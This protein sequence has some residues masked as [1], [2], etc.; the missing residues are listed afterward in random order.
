MC[1]Y[2]VHLKDCVINERC[3]SITL[4]KSQQ[5]YKNKKGG[6]G[7]PPVPFGWSPFTYMRAQTAHYPLSLMYREYL[8][9]FVDK[10]MLSA[11]LMLFS[12]PLNLMGKLFYKKKKVVLIS[13]TW[14]L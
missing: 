10:E 8:L 7:R 1:Q 4:I 5:N 13:L 2:L 9:S 12:C 3:I 6:G 11:L 14:F